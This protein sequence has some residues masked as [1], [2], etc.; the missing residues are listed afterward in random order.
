MFTPETDLRS[1]ARVKVDGVASTLTLKETKMKSCTRGNL[2]G[3]ERRWHYAHKQK[4]NRIILL[5]FCL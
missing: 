5:V 2:R 1:G 4:T 3:S